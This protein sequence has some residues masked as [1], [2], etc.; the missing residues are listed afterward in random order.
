MKEIRLQ[1]VMHRKAAALHNCW[2]AVPAWGARPGD[3]DKVG[4]AWSRLPSFP[5]LFS[6]LRNACLPLR[7]AEKFHLFIISRQGRFRMG[8]QES[9]RFLK[10]AGLKL[11]NAGGTGTAR[12]VCLS[13][14]LTHINLL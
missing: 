7:D 11:I 14:L 2:E 4:K 8:G 9:S 5:V 12:C 1:Q 6:G 13:H 10:R 3:S